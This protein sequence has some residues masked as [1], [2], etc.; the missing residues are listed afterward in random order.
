MPPQSEL[1]TSIDIE[2]AYRTLFEDAHVIQHAKIVRSEILSRE[3]DADIMLVSELD[4]ITNSY[5]IR[6]VY[7]WFASNAQSNV[8][9]VVA[10]DADNHAAAVAW[11]AGHFGVRTTVHI[12]ENTPQ[13]NREY[14]QR[15]GGNAVQLVTDA[16]TAKA[17][18]LHT[19]GQAASTAI[20]HPHDDIHLVAGQ[21]TVGLEII[22]NIAHVDIISSP[23]GYG[24]L[25]SGLIYATKSHRNISY[26]GSEPDTAAALSHNLWRP[27]AQLEHV[28][29][30]TRD[31]VQ[32]VGNIVLQT[33]AE[34]DDRFWVV[35][36]NTERLLQDITKLQNEK[37][38][39]NPDMCGVLSVSALSYIKPYIQGK[40]VACVLSSSSPDL[41]QQ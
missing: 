12:S 27:D 21:G 33:L 29:T 22:D 24:N 20:I 6:G 30:S 15:L 31:V 39:L 23:I 36:P 18:A 19:A 8:Q 4:Q 38:N 40:T 17:D 16:E 28:D 7:N 10:Y 3:F 2:A 37:N 9:E 41:L 14:I 13:Q 35:R 25:L 5:K 1:S 11:C 26:I 34:L 32:K